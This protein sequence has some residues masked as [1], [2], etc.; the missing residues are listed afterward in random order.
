MEQILRDLPIDSESS[1]QLRKLVDLP[2][3]DLVVK[4]DTDG[5]F[6]IE[7]LSELKDKYPLVVRNSQDGLYEFQMA[8]SNEHSEVIASF[9]R[10]VNDIKICSRRE[11]MVSRFESMVSEVIEELNQCDEA[12]SNQG[13]QTLTVVILED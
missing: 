5:D 4:L 12:E 6:G 8:V 1:K 11:Y 3:K 10:L 9:K 7:N 13:N 2:P